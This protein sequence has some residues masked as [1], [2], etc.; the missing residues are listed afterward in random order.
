VGRK[1]REGE[2]ANN[3]GNRPI[4]ESAEKIKADTTAS[5][6]RILHMRGEGDG[7]TWGSKR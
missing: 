4:E 5:I 6:I 3:G 2:A 7:T 1:K